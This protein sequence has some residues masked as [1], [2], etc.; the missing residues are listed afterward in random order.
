MKNMAMPRMMK[1]SMTSTQKFRVLR[2]D[3]ITFFSFPLAVLISAVVLSSFSSMTSR[4]GV[5]RL[6]SSSISPPR[7]FKTLRPLEISSKPWSCRCFASSNSSRNA[8]ESFECSMLTPWPFSRSS[9]L[10]VTCLFPFPFP[11]VDPVPPSPPGPRGLGG[12]GGALLTPSGTHSIWYSKLSTCDTRSSFSS[13][14][15]PFIFL[16]IILRSF[17]SSPRRKFLP[18][19]ISAFAVATAALFFSALISSDLLM[20]SLRLNWREWNIWVNPSDLPVT[21]AMGFSSGR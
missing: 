4:M 17:G 2:I 13:S 18:R 16:S 9:M 3:V 19:R 21:G 15:S 11:P 14:V 8:R 12:A 5:C 6:I 7:F 10:M 20:R 1:M